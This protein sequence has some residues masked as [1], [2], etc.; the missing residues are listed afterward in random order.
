MTPTR[1]IYISGKVVMQDGSQ[2]PQGVTIQRVCSGIVKPVAQTDAKGR[3]S[4]RWNDAKLV[5]TDASD[6]GSGSLHS[7]GGGF[8][9]PQSAGAANPLAVDP[10]GSRMMNCDLRAYL[11]GFTSDGF[12]SGMP[13]ACGIPTLASLCCAG[14]EGVEGSSISVTS[15]LA[16]DKARKAYEHGMQNLLKNKPGDAARDFEKAVALYPGYADAWAN[17][18]KLLLQQQAIEPAR[19]ALRKAVEADPKLVAP[20]VELGVMAA[21]DANWKESAEL[22]DRAVKLDPVDFPQAWYADAGGS[23]TTSRI[24]SPRRRALREAVKLDPRHVNPRSSLPAGA[25][26][27]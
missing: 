24:T 15:M 3:F 14:W 23:T 5:V 10:F 26:S 7:S 17:L 16:P 6:A 21:K 8:G 22:L 12:T 20:W 18:G 1:L 25:G 13:M 2:V 9:S 19:A 4:F 27:G 11:A